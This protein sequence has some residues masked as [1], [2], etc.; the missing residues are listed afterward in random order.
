MT[1]YTNIITVIWR[2]TQRLKT[3]RGV[4]LKK[5]VFIIYNIIINSSQLVHVP[6]NTKLCNTVIF[7]S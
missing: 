1:E 3:C 6:H 2:Y 4:H 5:Y 7:N